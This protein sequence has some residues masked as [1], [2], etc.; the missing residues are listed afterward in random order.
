MQYK[1]ISEKKTRGKSQSQPIWYDLLKKKENKNVM[2]D[3]RNR[4]TKTPEISKNKLNITHKMNLIKTETHS[5]KWQGGLLS[6]YMNV[7]LLLFL[8]LLLWLF[9]FIP[10]HRKSLRRKT[11]FYIFRNIFF[12]FFFPSL[13][14]FFFIAF[15]KKKIKMRE[16]KNV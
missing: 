4:R 16:K 9:Y 12:F 3:E 13:F 6:S 14:H 5:F 1:R 7:R 10:H 11:R 15:S 8:K 2:K